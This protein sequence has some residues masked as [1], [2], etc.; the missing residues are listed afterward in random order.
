MRSL[1]GLDELH[2]SISHVAMVSMQPH[3]HASRRP[4]RCT[5]MLGFSAAVWANE[6]ATTRIAPRK[7]LFHRYIFACDSHYFRPR[8]LQLHFAGNQCHQRAEDEYQRSK[9]DPGDQREHVQ[10]D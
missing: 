5:S 6:A 8:V 10:L 3:W 2:S 7:L 1:P 4:T 9:P